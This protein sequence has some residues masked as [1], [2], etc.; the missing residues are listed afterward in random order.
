MLKISF[1]TL[2]LGCSRSIMKLTYSYAHYVVFLDVNG[3]ALLFQM[4]N[5]HKR[6]MLIDW[7][8]SSE[9]M[10]LLPSLRVNVIMLH[11]HLPLSR[12][13]CTLAVVNW[14]TDSHATLTLQQ[15]K[16]LL[17]VFVNFHFFK[18]I[19]LQGVKKHEKILADLMTKVVVV[20]THPWS[21]LLLTF[22]WT[23]SHIAKMRTTLKFA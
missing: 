21:R 11:H 1:V 13:S 6:R 23:H 3:F 22:L 15:N 14:M 19:L 10:L 4:K 12:L 2:A 5:L 16:S 9:M 20:I 17:F 18:F 8:L 7:L